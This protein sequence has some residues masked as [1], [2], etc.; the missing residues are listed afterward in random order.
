MN[1][2]PVGEIILYQRGDAPA[3]DVRLDGDTVW[4]SLNQI[5]DL[6]G[7]DKSTISRHI[8]NVFTDGELERTAK[9]TGSNTSISMWSSPSATGSSL[10]KAPSSASGPPHVCARSPRVVTVRPLRGL[11]HQ[12][13]PVA[14]SGPKPANPATRWLSEVEARRTEAEGQ[15]RSRGDGGQA[16]C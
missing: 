12:G 13:H 11:L 7:R 5:A 9:H 1:A 10:A 2:S 6:L 4:L 3:I 15:R 14:A 16:L 8:A